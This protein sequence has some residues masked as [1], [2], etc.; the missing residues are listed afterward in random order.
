MNFIV[1]ALL[2]HANEVMAF[3]LFVSLIEDCEMR[4]IYMH[5]LPGLFKHS[6][7]I[8]TLVTV[9]LEELSEHFVSINT[10]CIWFRTSTTSEWRCMP[11]TGSSDSLPQWSLSNRCRTSL[12]SS[13]DIVGSSTISWFYRFWS[14]WRRSSCRKT[15]FGT[16]WILLRVRL[17]WILLQ[18]GVLMGFLLLQRNRGMKDSRMMRGR[19]RIRWKLS[20]T[21]R[22]KHLI[23]KWSHSLRSYSWGRTQ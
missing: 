15:S 20:R 4:D 21:S 7:I 18:L 16:F 5:G 19:I 1:G 2:Y 3:W 9:N 13:T 14:S 22:T 23:A 11:P 12:P 8:N 17:F 6:H 10:P